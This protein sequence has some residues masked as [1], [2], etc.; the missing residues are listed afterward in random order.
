MKCLINLTNDQLGI[1][2]PNIQLLNSRQEFVQKKMI[3]KILILKI[4]SQSVGGRRQRLEEEESVGLRVGPFRSQHPIQD[5]PS[6][7]AMGTT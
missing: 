5:S 6:V 7:T 4:S 2:L 1:I 3:P